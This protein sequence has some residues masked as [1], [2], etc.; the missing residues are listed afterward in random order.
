MVDNMQDVQ[1]LFK[2][3]G[4]I[5][6]VP[7]IHNTYKHQMLN[8]NWVILVCVILAKRTSI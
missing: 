8:Y 6:L 1:N 7:S 5:L 4:H 3:N 2:Q